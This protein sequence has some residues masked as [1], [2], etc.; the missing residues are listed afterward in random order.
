MVSS[1]MNTV[2]TPWSSALLE[3]L[4]IALMVKTFFA[5]IATRKFIALFTGPRNWNL[6]RAG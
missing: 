1:F 6:R 3:N 5:L 2:T 4:I